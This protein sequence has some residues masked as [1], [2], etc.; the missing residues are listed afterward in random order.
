MNKG[1]A[2]GFFK[3]KCDRV[4]EKTFYLECHTHKMKF[5]AETYT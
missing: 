1:C 4:A 2:N 5:G 3:G